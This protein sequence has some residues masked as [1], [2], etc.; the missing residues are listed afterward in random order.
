M[1][2]FLYHSTTLLTFLSMFL[3]YIIAILAIIYGV[4]SIIGKASGKTNL[5]GGSI[6]IVLGIVFIIMASMVVRVPAQETGVVITPAGVVDEELHTGWHFIAPWNTV[7]MMDK[8]E[9]VYTFSHSEKDGSKRDADA[10]WAPTKDGIK[11]GLD[12]SIS[13]KI[14]P[15]QAAWVYANISDMDGGDEGRYH[16][17]EQNIIRTKAKSAIALT[18]SNYTPIEVYSTKREEIQVRVVERLKKELKDKNL[19]LEQVDI[20]EVFY[21]PEYEVAINNK[22]LAEQEALRLFEVTRQK[23]EMLKQAEI[24]KR[25]AIERAQGE[26]EALKIKGQSI[27]SNPKIIQL[28]WI[29][30]WDGKLPV[31]MM[32]DKGNVMMNI[33]PNQ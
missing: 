32:G 7:A 33:N 3:M 12:V 9:W 17:I 14:D 16:W 13:W 18:V 8:T 10:I 15:D 29:D 20:R 23:E 28:E 22:K 5:P 25:I 1:R 31:Y 4:A 24:D 27:S 30:K 6:A 19:L 21:N 26:S 11:M 2:L